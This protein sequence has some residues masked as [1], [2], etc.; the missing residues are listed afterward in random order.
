ME[1]R[2]PG[3]AWMRVVGLSEMKFPQFWLAPLAKALEETG[4]ADFST[5]AGVGA[6]AATTAGASILVSVEV[7]VGLGI[8]WETTV[9]VTG[10]GSGPP[11]KTEPMLESDKMINEL[12]VLMHTQKRY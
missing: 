12:I 3:A 10:V 5:T 2:P 4:A 1:L 11:N 8:S 9:L 6:G 7:G